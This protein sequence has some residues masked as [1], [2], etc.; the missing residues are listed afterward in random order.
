MGLVRS[1]TEGYLIATAVSSHVVAGVLPGVLRDCVRGSALNGA[2]DMPA[3]LLL[4]SGLPRSRA[5][6]Y[7]TPIGGPK[8]SEAAKFR[9]RAFAESRQPG[10]RGCVVRLRCP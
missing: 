5:D 1:P 4:P 2:T 3:E 10:L 8:Q 9:P 7:A 6:A